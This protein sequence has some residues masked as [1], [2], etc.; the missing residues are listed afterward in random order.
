[1]VQLEA[2]LLVPK[3]EAVPLAFLSQRKQDIRSSLQTQANAD[4]FD[5]MLVIIGPS[6]CTCAGGQPGA[7]EVPVHEVEIRPLAL[8]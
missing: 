2:W 7:V 3:V 5:A 1:M 4:Y 6:R 8:L